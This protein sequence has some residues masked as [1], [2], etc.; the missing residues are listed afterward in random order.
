METTTH[1]KVIFSKRL[2]VEPENKGNLLVEKLLKAFSILDIE[3]ISDLIPED[4]T[5]EG[6][7]N[8]YGF[9]AEYKQF[10]EEIEYEYPYLNYPLSVVPG[11]CHYCVLKEFCLNQRLVYCFI[12]NDSNYNKLFSMIFEI[13]KNDNLVEMFECKMAFHSTLPKH[14]NFEEIS[15]EEEFLQ[16]S[17]IVTMSSE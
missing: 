9:L 7:S 2:Q 8:K 1:A 11:N 15:F 13:D 16:P 4:S 17:I 5:F 6:Y 14:M 10:F 12:E 3:A